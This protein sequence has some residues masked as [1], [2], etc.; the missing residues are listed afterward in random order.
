MSASLLKSKSSKN[1]NN[2]KNLTISLPID[3]YPPKAYYNNNLSKSLGNLSILDPGTKTNSSNS[4]SSRSPI[5]SSF[6]SPTKSKS[7]KKAIKKSPLMISA[8]FSPS[9]A[10]FFSP[11]VSPKSASVDKFDNLH[12]YDSLENSTKPL[13]SV[14]LVTEYD[15]QAE[16][17]EELTI[18]KRE[19]LRLL[20]RPGDGWLKVRKI[21]NNRSGLIPASYVKIHVNDLL[22]P[23]THD[24]L[25]EIIPLE[26]D[27]TD[28][29]LSL[30]D[31]EKQSR[32]Y[33]K[34]H[35]YDTTSIK[36]VSKSNSA[37]SSISQRGTKSQIVLKNINIANVL[38]KDDR[39]WYRIDLKLTNNDEI[40]LLK[41]YH[42]FYT[43]HYQL[44]LLNFDNLPNFPQ[45]IKLSNTNDKKALENI[46]IRCAELNVYMNKVVKFD[47]YKNS[48]EIPE[49]FDKGT[50]IINPKSNSD[51]LINDRLLQ[52]SIS[53]I[54]LLHPTHDHN[55]KNFAPT[56]PLPM[57]QSE[58]MASFT[59]FLDNYDQA[60]ISPVKTKN[61]KHGS[62]DSADSNDLGGTNSEYTYTSSSRDDDS[63]F[64][65]SP[66][67]PQGNKGEFNNDALSPN[68]PIT[69]IIPD[70]TLFSN[71]VSKPSTGVQNIS[72]FITHEFVK[73]KVLLNNIENDIVVIKVKTSNID[74][75]IDV[76]RLV[77]Y[78]I[79]KDIGL[80]NHYK[81]VLKNKHLS[82]D[83]M[84]N[85]IK[86]SNKVTL[87]LI[88]VRGSV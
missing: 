79:Y 30:F 86:T 64:S 59:S 53:L 35:G 7:G 41:D 87:T 54:D 57:S 84:V 73:I 34:E 20:E 68:T 77:S 62:S 1:D 83:E 70:K 63:V 69:P 65:K 72:K 58:S 51:E 80:I 17:N 8:P 31:F 9:T 76:K 11:D 10:S 18:R 3:D 74:S 88:R 23:I 48:S 45:P 12:N 21:S 46:L 32:R 61:G 40:Y 5:L 52:D 85:H 27:T 26:V 49:F 28:E 15:F 14:I 66:I 42:E 13:G 36:S 33:Q 75:M 56:A 39:F 67:T 78:K 38:T 43:L 47:Y 16:S 44:S 82:D 19:F 25:N 29:G 22:N 81:L 37:R 2:I 4:P 24:W 6:K 50:K 71:N 55:R 60:S